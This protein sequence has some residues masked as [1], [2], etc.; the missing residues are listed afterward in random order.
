MDTNLQAMLL[1]AASAAFTPGPNNLMITASGTNFGFWRSVPHMMGVTL[2]FPAMLIAMAFGLI[3]IFEAWPVL[4]VILRYAGAAY[5]IYLAYR[6]ATSKSVGKAKAAEQPLSFI[7]AALF[8]WINPKAVIFSL[9]ALSM[10]TTPNGNFVEET[11]RLALVAL[12]VS[13]TSISTWCLFG[14]AIRHLLK[15]PKALR[16]FNYTMAGALVASIALILK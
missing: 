11:T 14:T 13:S 16:L 1:F 12:L 15:S 2:G 6:I 5:M 3:Q 9:S 7:E 10:F 8:Q 4:H